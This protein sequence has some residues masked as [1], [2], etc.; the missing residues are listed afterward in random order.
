MHDQ[1][2]PWQQ[3]KVCFQ[4]DPA[5]RKKNKLSH[6]ICLSGLPRWLSG[7][8][9]TCQCRR[10]KRHG[11]NPWVGKI[12]WRRKWQPTPV[13]LPGQFHGQRSLAV[14]GVAKSQ[15]QL[16]GWAHTHTHTHT[17]TLLAVPKYAEASW[18][19]QDSVW[20]VW[21]PSPS[22]LGCPEHEWP[23]FANDHVCQRSSRVSCVSLWG[24]WN[25]YTLLK[26]IALKK[27]EL[28]LATLT[29]AR[30]C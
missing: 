22:N 4:E 17:H 15:T 1:F 23:T 12:P 19:K 30:N 11:C 2:Y 20:A 14:H 7:K 8:K 3:L 27:M 10:H 26:E 18:N 5:L 16:S 28:H 29:S 25:S 6:S 13:F 21:L 24:F 9:S